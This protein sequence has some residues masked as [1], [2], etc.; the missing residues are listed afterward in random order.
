MT[1]P[2][3][4][5]D[6]FRNRYAPR[7]PRLDPDQPALERRR[8]TYRLDEGDGIR[9]LEP[10][11]AADVRMGRPPTIRDTLGINRY[12]WVI[13][14]RGIPYIIERD[15]PALDGE[16]PKHTNLTGGEE[17]YIGGEM[18]FAALDELHL[19]GGSGR[20]APANSAQL[21]DAVRVFESFGYAVTSLGWNDNWGRARRSAL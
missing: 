15:T 4:E 19:S 10:A 21:E 6:A 13:D 11:P 18:W 16:L 7:P 14:A 20:Y 9:L 3:D 17:A 8:Q 12:L 2:T 1:P 5:L